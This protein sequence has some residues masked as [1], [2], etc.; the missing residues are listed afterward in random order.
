MRFIEFGFCNCFQA[1]ACEDKGSEKNDLSSRSLYIF[2]VESRFFYCVV[3]VEILI[4][5]LKFADSA[6]RLLCA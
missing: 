4:I 6:L 1:V 2:R 3:E 5:L